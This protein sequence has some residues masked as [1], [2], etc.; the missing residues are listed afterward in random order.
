[1][2][3]PTGMQT[4]KPSGLWTGW[5]P[6]LRAAILMWILLLG[7]S[8]LHSFTGGTSLVFVTRYSFSYISV[9]GH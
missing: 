5:H 2:T 4:A 3:D 8:V 9:M 1:M 6:G 7:I